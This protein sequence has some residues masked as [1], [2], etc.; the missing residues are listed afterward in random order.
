MMKTFL[1]SIILTETLLLGFLFGST[2]ELYKRQKKSNACINTILKNN[3][4]INDYFGHLVEYKNIWIHAQS[5]VSNQYISCMNK[6][7]NN[8]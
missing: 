2:H 6:R 3:I 1:I 7:E 8:E 5:V 4:V